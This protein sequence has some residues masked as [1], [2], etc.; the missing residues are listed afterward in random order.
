M[1]RIPTKLFRRSP[2]VGVRMN[3]GSII[4]D[5]RADAHRRTETGPK[6]TSAI[7]STGI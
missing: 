6:A 7:C 2:Q 5:G 1:P 4:A 3:E